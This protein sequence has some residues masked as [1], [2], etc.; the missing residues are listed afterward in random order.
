MSVKVAL[1]GAVVLSYLAVWATSAA[2]SQSQIYNELN[3]PPTGCPVREVGCTIYN[4]PDRIQESVKEGLRIAEAA[5]KRSVSPSLL[6]E[7]PSPE[8]VPDKEVEIPKELVGE[9]PKL[10]FSDFY[11]EA[12][13]EPKD[14]IER[15]GD[16]VRNP[17]NTK[18]AGDVVE[19]FGFPREAAELTWR[20]Y[21]AEADLVAPSKVRR[22]GE[23]ETGFFR[24]PPGYTFCN[25]ELLDEPDIRQTKDHLVTYVGVVTRVRNPDGLTSDDGLAYKIVIPRI[26][27]E[28]TW[29]K[30]H[31]RLIYIQADRQLVIRLTEEGKC[32][33]HNT[34]T[35]VYEKGDPVRRS[36][37]NCEDRDKRRDR[38]ASTSVEELIEALRPK[39]SK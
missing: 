34:C 4:T 33:A 5:R 22:I 1:T 18:V 13:S 2:Q 14:W 7:P 10:V 8:P 16:A 31:I 30:S 27:G 3:G 29:V 12:V 38:W 39:D 36:V 35:W 25:A 26:G 24:S 17:Q 28:S 6:G 19:K 21:G 20:W 15:F 11:I 23:E 37:F 32:V 9:Q